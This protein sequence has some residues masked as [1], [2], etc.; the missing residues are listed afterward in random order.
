MSMIALIIDY[1]SDVWLAANMNFLKHFL[2]MFEYW[3]RWFSLQY[4][5]Y[6]EYGFVSVYS[7]VINRPAVNLPETQSKA[8]TEKAL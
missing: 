8:N 1:F 3:L 6:D 5:L 7:A 4:R 2:S